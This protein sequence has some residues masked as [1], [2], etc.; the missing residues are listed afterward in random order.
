MKRYLYP[1]A[2]LLLLLGSCKKYLQEYSQDKVYPSSASDLKELL[3]GSGYQT[4]EDI[5][6]L[7]VM[8]D[9]ETVYM[10]GNSNLAYDGYHYWQRYPSSMFGTAYQDNAWAP[11]YKSIAVV[12]VCIPQ[13]EGF[14]RDTLYNRVKGESY[15]IR[16]MDYFKLI[17]LYAK[18]YSKT[19]AATDPGVPLKLTEYVEDKYF[20]RNSVGQVYDSIVYDLKSSIS[21]LKGALQSSNYRANEYAARGLLARVYLYMGNWQAASDQ[22]DSIISSGMYSLV[23]LNDL[24]GTSSFINAASPEVI[25]T[26]GYQNFGAAMNPPDWGSW[27]IVTTYMPSDALTGL[28]AANDLRFDFSFVPAVETPRLV[29]QKLK[30]YDTKFVSDVFSVRLAD[31]YLIKAESMAMMGKDADAVGYLKQLRKNRMKNGDVSGVDLSGDALIDTIRNE[32]RRE[33]CFEG[34]RWFDLR[35]YAVSPSHPVT[36]KIVHPHYVAQASGQV[37]QD[38]F[39]QLNTYEIDHNAFA[40]PIPATEIVVNNGELVD[41]PR[42]DRPVKQ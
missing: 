30:E 6:F 19:T 8:D 27:N 17:N 41:N 38:G 22:S 4:G 3:L 9:D 13:V 5:S 18:P 29:Y 10:N 23:N 1:A 39:Y 21:L 42:D 33:L 26:G 40:L 28:Y 32:R 37:I 35:R 36:Q 25:F 31:I 14:R 12:N 2:I 34:H 15:F 20:T 16:A 11:L 24:P 7:S